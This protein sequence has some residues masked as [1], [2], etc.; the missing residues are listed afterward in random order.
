MLEF[1]KPCAHGRSFQVQLIR[2][3]GNTQFNRTFP[4]VGEDLGT[5]VS[6]VQL[7]VLF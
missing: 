2:K 1:V 6:S 7:L 5:Q 4:H 3:I